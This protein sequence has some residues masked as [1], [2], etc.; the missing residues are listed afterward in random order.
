M[1]GRAG[2]NG[3]ANVHLLNRQIAGG[4]TWVISAEQAVRHPLRLHEEPGG[5]T[6]YGQGDPS[7]LTENG[8]TN[9]VPTDPSIVRDLNAQSVSGFTQFGAQ[10]SS[11][12]FQ[13]PT[14]YNPKANFTWV[15]GATR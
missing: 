11:P 6:P 12:Q 1:L 10:P 9:G 13:N 15:R 2:G 5:K 14:I 3:N 7:L 8:I 4:T